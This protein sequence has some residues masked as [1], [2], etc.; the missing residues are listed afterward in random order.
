[1][2]LLTM[3]DFSLPGELDERRMEKHD[4]AK[5]VARTLATTLK[6]KDTEIRRLGLISDEVT[7]V[8]KGKDRAKVQNPEPYVGKGRNRAK[9]QNPEI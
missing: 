7:R 8:G 1:M 9:I 5:D 3:R 2:T 6:A 4:C